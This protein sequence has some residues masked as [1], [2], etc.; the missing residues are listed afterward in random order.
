LKLHVGYARRGAP[1]EK[2]FANGKATDV[3]EVD[4][5]FREPVQ[6]I[7]IVQLGNAKAKF[8]AYS[9]NDLIAEKLRALLQQEKRNRNRRQDIYDIASLLGK[10]TLDE[11]EKADLL[12]LLQEKCA[13]RKL[14]C[15]DPEPDSL[16]RPEVKERARKEWDTL[17]MEIGNVPDFDECFDKVDVFYRSLPWPK[18]A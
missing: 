16:V 15:P 13:A 12:A 7:Q 2:L 9:L 17:A 18:T 1:Q 4:I 6:A 10:F 5:S 8:A 3:L 11:M 14:N